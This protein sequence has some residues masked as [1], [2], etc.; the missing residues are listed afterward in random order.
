MR[1]YKKQRAHDNSGYYSGANDRQRVD[2]EN[3]S[4]GLLLIAL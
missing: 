1:M 3:D 2:R 4:F